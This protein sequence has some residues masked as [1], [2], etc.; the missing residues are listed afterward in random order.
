MDNEWELL[1]EDSNPLLKKI[2]SK[3]KKLLKVTGLGFLWLIGITILI[4]LIL[5]IFYGFSKSFDF[6]L[7]GYLT[8]IFLFVHLIP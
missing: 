7:A 8:I 2:L 5:S 1:L 6:V 4:Y 3:I